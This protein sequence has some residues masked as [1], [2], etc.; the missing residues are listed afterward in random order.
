MRKKIENHSLTHIQ[1]LKKIL[2][3]KMIALAVK[4]N[5]IFYKIK[6]ALRII[7]K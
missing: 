2:I 6:K 1:H 7:Y 4:K 5:T 3:N